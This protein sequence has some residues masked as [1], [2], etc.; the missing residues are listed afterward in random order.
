MNFK[1][2]KCNYSELDQSAVTEE[3]PEG[4]E[5]PPADSENKWVAASFQMF[6]DCFKGIDDL[7]LTSD[8]F[9]TSAFTTFRSYPSVEPEPQSSWKPVS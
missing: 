1:F 9:P 3:T 8:H 4:E 7:P 2:K 6:F 5:H